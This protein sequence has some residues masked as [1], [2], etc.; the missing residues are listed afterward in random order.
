MVNTLMEM[1]LSF[2]EIKELTDDE[3]IMILATKIAIKDKEGEQLKSQAAA[4]QAPKFRMP[5]RGLY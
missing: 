3:Y 5:T 1:G 2:S 4:A